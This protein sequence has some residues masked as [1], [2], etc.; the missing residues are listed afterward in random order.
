MKTKMKKNQKPIDIDL[1]L[2]Y[3][4][5][6]EGCGAEH[7]VSLKEARTPKFIVVCY[8]GNKFSV[9]TIDKCKISYAKIKNSQA[10]SEPLAIPQKI[11]E[12]C[13]KI[14]CG[15]GFDKKESEELL[16][17]YYLKDPINDAVT[18]VKKTISSIGVENE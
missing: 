13:I 4:C 5:P 1:H 3:R 17:A 18:L 11:L 9:K 14:M 6:D 7:W 8:C 15:F 16:I 12:S 2:K 10:T